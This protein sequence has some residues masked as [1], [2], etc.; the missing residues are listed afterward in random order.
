MRTQSP[1][2]R[3]H[4]QSF[5]LFFII[6]TQM[7]TNNA[8]SRLIILAELSLGL[9]PSPSPISSYIPLPQ[10]RN[11]KPARTR[12]EDRETNQNIFATFHYEVKS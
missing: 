4:R 12:G 8:L 5:L 1:K 11:Q 9:S 6:S 2:V 7:Q 10:I 3:V